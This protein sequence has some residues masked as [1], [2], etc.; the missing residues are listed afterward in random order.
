M[1]NKFLTVTLI[2]ILVGIFIFL[3]NIFLDKTNSQNLISPDGKN[4]LQQ[5]TNQKAALTPSPTPTSI[6]YNFNKSTNLKEELDTVN[7]EVLNSDFD[8]L[9]PITSQL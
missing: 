3:G 7:P 8:S 9:K 4:I 6:Q 2:L 1:K 5:V